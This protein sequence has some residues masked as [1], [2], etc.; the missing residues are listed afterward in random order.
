MV[1]TF[2][3]MKSFCA[4]T[5]CLALGVSSAKAQ[6]QYV[7]LDIEWEHTADI[8]DSHYVPALPHDMPTNWVSP[9][10]YAAGT[11]HMWLEVRSKPTDAPTKVQVCY[12]GSPSYSCDYQSDAF[13]TTGVFEWS[14]PFS[15]FWS[16]DYTDWS[17]APRQVTVIV[18]DDKNN[19]PSADN[20][21]ATEAARY[22][23]LTLR[24]VVTFVP[25]GATY[26]PPTAHAGASDASMADAA[27]AQDAGTA[28]ADASGGALRRAMLG[29]RVQMPAPQVETRPA[30]VMAR[31][32]MAV[33][34]TGR[35]T[36]GCIRF[37]GSVG[38]A[39]ST[40]L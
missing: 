37:P 12:I 35:P 14:D 10:D 23:P 1:L 34:L 18:K 32:P 13:T 40:G 21:G 3:S 9:V 39:C 29:S 30:R 28:T 20:V 6:D 7:F 22:F 16:P 19:K 11:A 33:F 2:D 15:G 4:L 17:M 26:V 25:P 36:A 38:W 8:A 31:K 5:A 24:L 27:S